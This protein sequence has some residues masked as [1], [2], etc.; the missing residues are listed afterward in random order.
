MDLARSL[1]GSGGIMFGGAGMPSS[2]MAEEISLLAVG[3]RFAM[4][5]VD[6]DGDG[7]CDRELD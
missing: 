6:R 4:R 2:D 5:D 1:V 3:G 7:S